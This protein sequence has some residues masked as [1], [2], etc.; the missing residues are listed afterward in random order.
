MVQDLV[1]NLCES[2]VTD[3][4]EVL[5]SERKTPI[6]PVIATPTIEITRLY[7]ATITCETEGVTIYYT[8]NGDTPT[9]D[10]NEY[11]SAISLNGTCTIK[12]IAIKSGMT[13]SQVVSENYDASEAMSR[14]V[15]DTTETTNPEFSECI[16]D[17]DNRLLYGLRHDDSEYEPDLTGATINID[18]IDY[19]AQEILDFVK[20]NI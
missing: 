1:H 15:D 7:T 14:I 20:S 12:A 6:H 5:V 2:L 8:L 4:S 11:Q 13:N 9:A 10:S 16:V 19:S 18:G 3:I 17:Y